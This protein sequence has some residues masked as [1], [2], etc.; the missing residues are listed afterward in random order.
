LIIW[1]A[2]IDSKNVEPLGDSG[3]LRSTKRNSKCGFKIMLEEGIQISSSLMEEIDIWK[4]N[5]I[6]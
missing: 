5:L 6:L 2:Y 1:N 4:K 3:F